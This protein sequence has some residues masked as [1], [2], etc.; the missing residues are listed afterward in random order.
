ML[1]STIRESPNPTN[2][3]QYNKRESQTQQMLSRTTR[4]SLKPSR[5]TNISTYL[6]IVYHRVIVNLV[7][8]QCSPNIAVLV[9]YKF[10][11]DQTFVHICICTKTQKHTHIMYILYIW[12]PSMYC[13]YVHMY[14]MYCTYVH[15]YVR[16]SLYWYKRPM[17]YPKWTICSSESAF[18]PDTPSPCKQ[19]QKNACHV[20]WTYVPQV[21]A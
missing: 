19:F 1:S 16:I 4:E 7:N 20:L 21:K 17:H 18:S 8:K 3:K 14:S 9:N 15:M 2:A 12:Y 11:S 5:W 13:T 6:C 10:K